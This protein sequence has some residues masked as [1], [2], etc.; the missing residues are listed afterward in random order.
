M[1]IGD[2]VVQKHLLY[3]GLKVGIIKSTLEDNYFFY[4]V[5]ASNDP[6]FSNYPYPFQTDELKLYDSILNEV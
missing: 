3:I 5:E 4:Y 2:L 6:I 1:K